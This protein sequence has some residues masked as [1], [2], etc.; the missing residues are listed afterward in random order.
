MSDMLEEKLSKANQLRESEQFGESAKLFTECL[1]DYTDQQDY[2]GQIHSLCGQSLIYKIL[3]RKDQN[4]TY[5]ELTIDFSKS[6]LGVLESHLSQVD[7]H[8]QSIAYSSFADALLMDNQLKECLPYFEK[9]LSI[10]PADKPE[11]GRL[12][13]HIGGVKYMLGEKQNGIE[14]IKEGLQ[15][16]RTGDL[17]DYKIRVWETGALNGL[18]K[19]YAR[20][21]DMENAKKMIGDSLKIAT[22]HHLSIRKREAEEIEQKISSGDTNFPI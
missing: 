4:Q 11:K 20:E 7:I 21:D 5:R 9:A 8:T 10:S 18:A 17:N 1:I 14:L 13:S 22:D 16:I 12:K 19:I 3:A 2:R 15:D 6:A